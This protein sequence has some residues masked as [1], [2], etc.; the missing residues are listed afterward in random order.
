MNDNINRRRFL[1]LVGAGLTGM[2]LPSI[3]SAKAIQNKPNFIV[4]LAD[5]LGYSSVN[6]YGADK[7]LVRTPHIDS[8]AEKG[9]RFTN[10]YTPASICT[11]TRHGLL[12]GRYPWRTDLKYGV[13]HIFSELLPDTNRVTI[14][15]WLN[16]RGYNTAAIGKWHLGYGH[17]HNKKDPNIH[18]PVKKTTKRKELLLKWFA[19]NLRP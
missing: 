12:T 2:L 8:I 14:A 16:D 9:V 17:A 7:K 10:A 1:K 11:P 13:T 3:L 19:K 18:T 15:D 4:I 6:S 5:D